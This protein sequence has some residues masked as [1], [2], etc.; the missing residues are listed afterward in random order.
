MA[1]SIV[2][3]EAR[4]NGVCETLGARLETEDSLIVAETFKELS[5][6]RRAQ[7]NYRGALAELEKALRIENKIFSSESPEVI[8]LQNEKAKLLILFRRLTEADDIIESALRCTELDQPIFKRLK[9]DLLGQRGILQD[10]KREYDRAIE[11]IAEAINLKKELLGDENVEL[12]R[13]YIEKAVVLRHQGKH[14]EALAN[15]E[16]AHNID[17]LHFDENHIYFARI[18]LE[19]GQ[20]YLDKRSVLAAQE[21]LKEALKIYDIQ[22]NRNTKQHA[23]AAE[24]LGRNY[25]E[26]GLLRD[27]S[28]RFQEAMDIRTAIY[29]SS[30]PEIAETLYHQAQALLKMS[31]AG[32]NEDLKAKARQKFEQARNMLRQCNDINAE[33]ISDIDRTLTDL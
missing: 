19:Q 7:G 13:L 10:H 24:A 25:L 26:N 9:S 23:D 15:L 12:A 33:L 17:N 32:E 18:L 11:N 6:I 28:V 29:G 22:P 20:T 30:H 1:N 27:A 14:N 8:E 21:H 4:I 3:A 5:T 31:E 16:T 2:G